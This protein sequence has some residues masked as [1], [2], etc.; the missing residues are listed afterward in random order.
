MLIGDVFKA[1]KKWLRDDE[2]DALAEYYEY[3]R[4]EYQNDP[5]RGKIEILPVVKKV[6]VQ[7][8]LGNWRYENRKIYDER[9]I[10]K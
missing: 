8:S 2:H 7:D 5:R 3:Y 10:R 1:V 9:Y 6:R 4:I